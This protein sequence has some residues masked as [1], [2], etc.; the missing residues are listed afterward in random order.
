MIAAYFEF[1]FKHT[2]YEYLFDI[3]IQQQVVKA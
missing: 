2:W 1:F 3:I